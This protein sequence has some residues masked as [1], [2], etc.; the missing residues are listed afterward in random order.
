MEDDWKPDKFMTYQ[1]VSD[2]SVIQFTVPGIEEWTEEEW[3]SAGQ[4]DLESYVTEPKQY[5]L[6]ESWE[7]ND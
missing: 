3:D 5:Y 4:S 7:I 1:Y 2:Y 6:D